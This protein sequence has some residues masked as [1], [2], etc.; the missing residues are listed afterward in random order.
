MKK[1]SM[2]TSD[3]IVGRIFSFKDILVPFA[4][5]GYLTLDCNKKPDNSYSVAYIFGI[6]VLRWDTT[7]KMMTAQK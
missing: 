5:R 3:G 7:F 4:V 1:Q 6:R 2:L